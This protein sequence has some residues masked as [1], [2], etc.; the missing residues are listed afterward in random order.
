MKRM[1]VLLL[2]LA[3]ACGGAPDGAPARADDPALTPGGAR[4]V[5]DREPHHFD[6]GT[7][8]PG[9]TFLGLRVVHTDVQ[10]VFEDSVWSGTV[11]FAGEVEVTGV[12]QRHF[13]YPEPAALCFHVTDDASIRRLPDFAPDTWTSTNARHWFCFSNADDAV[14]LLGAGEEP[15]AATIAI[16]DFINHRLF[17]DAVDEARLLRVVAVRGSAPPTLRV[18]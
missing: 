7:L 6:A 13:D 9:D 12:Y 10:R 1:P 16:D 8:A 11:R 15:V 2:V 18:P 3:A 14:R 17:T 5:P 4:F